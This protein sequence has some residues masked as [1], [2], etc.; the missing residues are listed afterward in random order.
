MAWLKLVRHSLT[1]C[2]FGITYN[3]HVHC[4]HIR[5]TKLCSTLWSHIDVFMEY[6]H[7]TNAY[8]QVLQYEHMPR[9]SI[10]LASAISNHNDSERYRY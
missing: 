1:G 4:T 3:V 8:I 9:A 10:C 2:F 5:T 7:V 6:L